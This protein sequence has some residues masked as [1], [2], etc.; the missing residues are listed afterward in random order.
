MAMKSDIRYRL[1]RAKVALVVF[2]AV[3]SAL[4]SYEISYRF[5]LG[6]ETERGQA[7]G[8]QSVINL[9][10]MLRQHSPLVFAISIDE[11]SNDALNQLN[12]VSTSRWLDQLANEA[13]LEAL[14]IMNADGMT[15]A[16]SNYAQPESFIGQRYNFRPY[17]TN[18][19]NGE[20]GSFFA[21]GVTTGKPGYFLSLPIYRQGKVMGVVAAKVGVEAFAALWRGEFL[22]GFITSEDDVI[23]LSSDQSW[24]Y[25]STS[26]L[27]EPQQQLMS[28]KR[29]FSDT[30]ITSLEANFY[31]G[32]AKIDGKEWIHH[33]FPLAE[34]QWTMHTLRPIGWAQSQASLAAFV[35]TSIVLAIISLFLTI[36]TKRVRRQ[37]YQ[38]EHAKN[39]LLNVNNRLEAEILD[40]KQAQNELAKAQSRLVQSGRMAALGQ[41]SASVIHELGQPL[42][43]LKNYLVAAEMSAQSDADKRLIAQ[44]HAVSNRMQNT[45]HELR[46]FSRPDRT[47]ASEVDLISVVKNALNL[48]EDVIQKVGATV[49]STLP[50]L[51]L[52]Q[53]GRSQRLEQVIMNLVTNAC[54]ALAGVE[55]PEIELELSQVD[56]AWLLRVE[57]NGRGFGSADP[58]LLFEAFY[59]TATKGN[60][61]GLGLAISAAIVSEHHGKIWAQSAP[62]GGAIFFLKLPQKV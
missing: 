35:V 30:D 16:A 19:I 15:V 50:A 43:M 27:T 53:G 47:Q 37:L 52:M 56:D 60:S 62:K 44:L 25:T 24:L 3:M 34:T 11:R 36:R 58:E 5:Y 29:Q 33:S 31:N 42:S 21:I 28:M 54:R 41:L 14:Y 26:P 45:T 51:A 12:V 55:H 17:F 59:T 6:I 38:S 1:S 9:Q 20:P 49:K 2:C 40:R 46:A 61:L 13:A 32:F 48:T 39:E 23:I 8:Q 57:D 10:Y 7:A 18:A 22:D 4:V